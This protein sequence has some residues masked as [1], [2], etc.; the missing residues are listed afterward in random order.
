MILN[1]TE[2][3]GQAARPAYVVGPGAYGTSQNSSQG[4]VF[5]LI[6]TS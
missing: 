3:T 2:T 4:G 6:L 1:G 5:V